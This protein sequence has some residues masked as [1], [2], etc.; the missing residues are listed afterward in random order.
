M[1][2]ATLIAFIISSSVAAACDSPPPTRGGAPTAVASAK[3]TAS[4]S[5]DKPAGKV[6]F[7]TPQSGDIVFP[8]VEAAFGIQGWTLAPAGADAPGKG[9]LW[10]L[11]GAD[12]VAEGEALTRDAKHLPFAT[13]ERSGTIQLEPGKQKLTLQLASGSGKSLGPQAAETIEI[14]VVPSQGERRV[15][16]AEPKDGAKVTSPVKVKFA[17]EGMKIRPAGQ[18]ANERIS[19]HHHLFI[20]AKPVAVGTFIP[21]DD[22]HIHYGGGETEVEVE[23]PKGEH[24]LTAQFGD[25]AHM[26]YGPSMSATIKV[27]VE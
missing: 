20:D 5:A 8:E 16:F 21:R 17:V 10:V 19:G 14:E 9:H 22:R 12:P 15:S 6:F 7:V 3:A 13:G 11:V 18:A 26:S 1:S 24:T 4:A 2:R 23:L 27:T 25:G